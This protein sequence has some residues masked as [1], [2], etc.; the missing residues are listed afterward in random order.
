MRTER[1][2]RGREEEKRCEG[3]EERK[4]VSNCCVER[5]KIS[6]AADDLCSVSGL[7]LAGLLRLRLR[8]APG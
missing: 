5:R 2:G 3:E 1:E 8:R 6:A 7:G 4:E